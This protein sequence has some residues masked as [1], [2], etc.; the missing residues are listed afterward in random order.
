MIFHCPRCRLPLE[1]DVPRGRAT[2]VTCP[3]CLELVTVHPPAPIPALPMDD[4]PLGYRAVS[5]DVE[6]ELQKDLRAVLWGIFAFAAA[7]VIGY[8]LLKTRAGLPGDTIYWFGWIGGV[9][10]FIAIA[11]LARHAKR[12]RNVRTGAPVRMKSTGER[13]GSV[14]VLGITGLLL[15]GLTIL[16][17][18]VLLFAVCI[19]ALSGGGRGF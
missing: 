15:I 10:A 4:V 12:S 17:A 11:M 8:L 3:A 16:A 6:A 5:G 13:V 9:T 19:V 2:L 18:V 14:V 7:A 1:A